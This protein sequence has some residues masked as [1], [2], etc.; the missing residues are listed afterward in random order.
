[1]TASGTAGSAPAGSALFV[2]IVGIPTDMTVSGTADGSDTA[3][4]KIAVNGS[5]QG[6]TGT[7]GSGTWSI[8]D[9]TRPSAGHVITVWI[10]NVGDS[11]ESTAITTYSAA[12]VTGLVLNANT[13]TIGGNQD[14]SVSLTNLNAY[15]C[16]EDEDIMYQAASSH[17]KVEGDSCFGSTTNS[18]TSEKISILSGDTLAVGTSETVTTYDLDNAGTIT[19]TGNAT[20]NVARNWANTGTFTPATST[21]TLNG[22]DSSTQTLSGTTT[23][24][25]LS[26]STSSNSAGRTI[27]FTA[28]TTTAVSGTWT[29]TG[30]SSQIITLDSSTTATWTINP[31]AATSVMCRSPIQS[32]LAQFLSPREC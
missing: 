10:D 31:T 9:V 7:I 18:Y 16:T 28:G 15:D 20:Y 26:A 24:N 21:V 30:T 27:R 25:N 17:L 4:V 8:A 22:A 2:K 19:S 3:T 5:I 32:T 11:A 29:L 6:Q 23:F 12:P 1:M 14:T 13:L